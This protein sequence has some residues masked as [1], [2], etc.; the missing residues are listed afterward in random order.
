ML[1]RGEVARI[2][3]IGIRPKRHCRKFSH[4]CIPHPARLFRPVSRLQ[5]PDI[6]APRH[7][8]VSGPLSFACHMQVAQPAFRTCAP[9]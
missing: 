9:G 8:A 3:K 1:Q 6:A 2:R 5:L 4:Y 7:R